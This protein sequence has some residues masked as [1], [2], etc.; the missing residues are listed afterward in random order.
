MSIWRDGVSGGGGLPFSSFSAETGKL[1]AKNRTSGQ[2]EVMPN[3]TSVCPDMLRMRKG[4]KRWRPTVDNTKMTWFHEPMNPIPP[5]SEGIYKDALEVPLLIDGVGLTILT[6]DGSYF[7]NWFYAEIQKYLHAAEAA[8][9]ELPVYA[10]QDSNSHYNAT[11]AKTFYSPGWRQIG[12]M[13]RSGDI[14]GAAAYASPRPQIQ[15]GGA[16]AAL[17]AAVPEPAEP[18][19]PALNDLVRSVG[20]AAAAPG[21]RLSA[22]GSGEVA[23]SATAATTTAAKASPFAGTRPLTRVPIVDLD[24]EAA[25]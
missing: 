13:P 22:P 14:Y 15:G 2:L 6:S 4:P 1:M 16:A 3:G 5:V 17:P 9:N 10:V 12:W 20:P 11:Y 8:R 7:G 24:N 18:T 21:S 25:D 23:Q 19:P